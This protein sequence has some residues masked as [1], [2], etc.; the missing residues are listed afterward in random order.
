MHIFRNDCFIIDYFAKE[1]CDIQQSQMH[2][3][4]HAVFQEVHSLFQSGQDI[5]GQGIHRLEDEGL[6]RSQPR[7]V[8][9]D[10]PK[11]LFDYRESTVNCV[12]SEAAARRDV[13]QYCRSFSSHR[14][15]WNQ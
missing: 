7:L 13:A 6:I 12:E 3:S 15:E 9:V 11:Q 5:F 10:I 4:A 14:V 1:D 2:S 8:P